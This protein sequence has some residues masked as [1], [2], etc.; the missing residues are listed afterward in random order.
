MCS[1]EKMQGLSYQLKALSYVV[2]DAIEKNEDVE[3][4]GEFKKVGQVD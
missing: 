4:I 2:P 1:L 3:G